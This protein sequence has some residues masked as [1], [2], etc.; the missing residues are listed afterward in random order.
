MNW[1]A[2]RILTGDR[3]KYLGLIFAIA[4]STFLIAQQSSLFVVVINRTR[5]FIA[6]VTDANIWVMA[7]ATRYIDEVY[8]LKDNDVERVRS[9][10]GV[11]W[12]VPFYK[13]SAR[14]LAPD[15]KFREATLLGVDDA[16]LA[17]AP[18]PRR[19]V[20][21]SIENLRDPDAVVID[22]AG[23]NFF[24]PGEPLT[25]GKTFEMNDH[26][27]KVV[28]IVSA[29]VPFGPLP[30]FYT[31]YS[32]ALDFV[33]RERKLLS[34]VLAKG[35][36]GA[37]LSDV[38]KRIE[39]QTGLQALS[40]DEFGWMTIWYYIH[41][42]AFTTVFGITVVVAII[43]GTVVAGQT[44]YMFTLENLKQFAAL[45][46]IGTT[47]GRIVR[48]I[49]LQAL[50][51]GALGYSI[52]IGMTTLAF[53]GMSHKP[54]TRD[55][56]LFWQTMGLAAGLELLIVLIASLASIRKILVL[57]TAVVFRG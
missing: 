9:V 18:E 40:S 45:K 21:G 38:T 2:L 42:T 54:P 49:L 26:R 36:P 3:A 32:L 34:F 23:Y 25:L 14:V 29:S 46:A 44:F 7:P 57:E 53:V 33:G 56:M 47:N 35:A 17:G 24:F 27:A 52:G 22:L 30:V 37:R 12:A 10:P 15:G 11:S 50:L 20:L 6:D 5:S 43:I 8:A 1:V 48:M 41:N 55:S 16:S 28:G 4:F 51:V 31:R 13:G 39:D 19:M